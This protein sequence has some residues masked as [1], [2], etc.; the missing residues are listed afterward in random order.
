MKRKEDSL[1]L[2]DNAEVSEA[3]NSK[4]CVYMYVCTHNSGVCEIRELGEKKKS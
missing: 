1:I 2:E 3:F 4:R